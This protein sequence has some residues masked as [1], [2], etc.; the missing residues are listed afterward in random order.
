MLFDS[1]FSSKDATFNML[2]ILS[3]QK[4]GLKVVHL[5]AQSLNN[6]LDEFRNLFISSGVDIV[7]ISETWFHSSIS[8]TVYQLPGF[9]LFRADRVTNAGGVC[10]YI[11]KGRY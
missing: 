10:T 4:S 7:C 6:K 2:R 8:D 1:S 5:N 9:Y 3:Q 11:Y